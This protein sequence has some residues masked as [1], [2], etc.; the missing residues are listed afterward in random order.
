MEKWIKKLDEFKIFIE[1]LTELTNK[2][3]IL[4]LSI[5]TLITIVLF[6]IKNL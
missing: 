5:G 2:L 6:V 3:I 4:A 1:K